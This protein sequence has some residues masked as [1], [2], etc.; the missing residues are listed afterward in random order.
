MAASTAEPPPERTSRATIVARGSSV[1]AAP[2][3]PWTLPLPIVIG[4]IP[5]FPPPQPGMPERARIKRRSCGREM[6]DL[7]LPANP[8]K[9][10]MRK[11]LISPIG[12]RRP[13]LRHGDH[14]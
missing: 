9:H 13:L 12:R 5:E 4:P 10:D 3:K 8:S 6:K 14:L 2:A 7:A 11:Q 1:A